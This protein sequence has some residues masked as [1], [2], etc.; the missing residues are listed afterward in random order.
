MLA[1]KTSKQTV[2]RF[3]FSADG[4]YL[5]VVG[6]GRKV[7]LWD[8]TAKKLKATTPPTLRYGTGARRVASSLGSASCPTGNCFPSPRWG[9]TQSTIPTT[10]KTAASEPES[11]VARRDSR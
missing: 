11:L 1:L 9:N 5:A 6:S 2:E 8:L 10:G 4:R 7:H 3:A